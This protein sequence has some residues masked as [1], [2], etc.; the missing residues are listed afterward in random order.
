MLDKI[1]YYSSQVIINKSNFSSNF[2]DLVFHQI[3]TKKRYRV[4]EK[5]DFWKKSSWFKLTTYID[6]LLIVIL[7]LA[8]FFKN[9]QYMKQLS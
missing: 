4:G 8:A 3:C 5:R 7:F 9:L 6:V 2:V 1:L